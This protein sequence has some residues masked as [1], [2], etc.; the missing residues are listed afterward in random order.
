MDGFLIMTCIK[1]DETEGFAFIGA[2][3][4]QTAAFGTVGSI[5]FRGLVNETDRPPVAIC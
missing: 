4:T 3:H 5:C 1:S 2:S